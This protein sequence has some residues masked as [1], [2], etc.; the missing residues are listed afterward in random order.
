MIQG[1]A[2]AKINY[3]VYVNSLDCIGICPDELRKNVRDCLSYVLLRTSIMLHRHETLG[4]P[5]LHHTIH[6][7]QSYYCLTSQ[8]L[9][10][11]VGFT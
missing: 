4:Y 9:H 3:I 5:V 2:A 11:V 6:F 10:S 1:V 8:S 7:S